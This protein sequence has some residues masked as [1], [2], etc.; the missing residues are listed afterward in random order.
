MKISQNMMKFNENQWFWVPKYDFMVKQMIFLMIFDETML[1]IVKQYV[2][3]NA[4]QKIMFDQE[5]DSDGPGGLK[6]CK[7]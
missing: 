4:F 2:K 5:F 7:K 6:K 3:K 1:N